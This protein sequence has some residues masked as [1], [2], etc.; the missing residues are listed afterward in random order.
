MAGV[1]KVILVGN[2]GADPEVKYLEGDNVVA[3]LRL[4]TT[5]AYKNRNGERV[6]QTEW[7]D[8][9]LW[10]GQAKVAEQYLKK[11]SQIYV[12]GKIKTDSWQDEQ[13]QNRYRTRIRV[14]SFT[15]LGSRPDG[16]GGG[17]GSAPQ[18]S[19]QPKPNAAAAATPSS[20]APATD[21]DDDDLPF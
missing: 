11:G 17:G 4:A 6:E 5:E 10:G 9:E 13:G 3:N 15:M 7:H 8:L 12:E 1:N 20:P 18:Q 16:A 2:L 14:L 19:Y 21:T